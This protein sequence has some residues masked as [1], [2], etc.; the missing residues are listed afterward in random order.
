MSSLCPF[1]CKQII[2]N[3]N[4]YWFTN[5]VLS[6]ELLDWQLS[7]AFRITDVGSLRPSRSRSRSVEQKSALIAYTKACPVM[8]PKGRPHCTR[9]WPCAM[10]LSR[11]L[12]KYIY[13]IMLSEPCI[14]TY[15]TGAN[16]LWSSHLL[17]CFVSS[18]YFVPISWLYIIAF[19]FCSK[20]IA[21]VAWGRGI[22]RSLSLCSAVVSDHFQHQRFTHSLITA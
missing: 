4:S 3:P 18:V 19:I 12:T 9:K 21:L 10:A 13:C 15:L 20:V 2:K 17:T 5:W 6:D 1:K 11:C 8:L 22:S 14:Y 7:S 16:L